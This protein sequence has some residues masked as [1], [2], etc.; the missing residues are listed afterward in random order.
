MKYKKIIDA[1]CH[2]EAR[3]YVARMFWDLP[4][5]MRYLASIGEMRKQFISIE[6]KIFRN[7]KKKLLEELT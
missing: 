2:N 7:K 1:I 3:E 5:D 4:P 6:N